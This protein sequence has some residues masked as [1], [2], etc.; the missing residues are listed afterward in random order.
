MPS[1]RTVPSK[2]SETTGKYQRNMLQLRCVT[3]L[4][5][6][7]S[8]NHI[9]SSPSPLMLS[10]ILTLSP[11]IASK[12]PMREVTEAVKEPGSFLGLSNVE[13]YQQPNGLFQDAPYS[14]SDNEHKDSFGETD[15]IGTLKVNPLYQSPFLRFRELPEDSPSET[16]I[17][18]EIGER[19]EDSLEVCG[20]LNWEDD[21]LTDI[22]GAGPT[23][24]PKD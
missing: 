22:V 10:N 14:T 24:Q 23:T 11:L 8:N 7:D 19:S 3:A 20:H 4:Q 21:M 16:F 2:S 6:Y 18:F 13:G 9:L 12:K 5:N 17:S 15:I 1:S